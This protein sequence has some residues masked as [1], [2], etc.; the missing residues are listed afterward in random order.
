MSAVL[1]HLKG[2]ARAAGY[3]FDADCEA[4]T[5]AELAEFSNL[6]AAVIDLER[7]VALLE[8]RA[9]RDESEVR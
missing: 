2:I 3:R 5:W 1:H 8:Q 9:G 7:R 4:E 6:R